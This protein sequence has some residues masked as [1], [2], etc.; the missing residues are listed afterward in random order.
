MNIQTLV[1]IRVPD[2][3]SE[4]LTTKTTYDYY[5]GSL[6]TALSTAYKA[7]SLGCSADLSG[8]KLTKLGAACQ[9]VAPAAR[10]DRKPSTLREKKKMAFSRCQKECIPCR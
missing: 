3:A 8:T 1:K 6:S 5:K 9:Y 10:N 4:L 7:F 2:Y